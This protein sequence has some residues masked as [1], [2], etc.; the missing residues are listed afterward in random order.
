MPL[1]SPRILATIY[2]SA[3]ALVII[4]IFASPA[5]NIAAPVQSQ[6]ATTTL[7]A[8]PVAENKES[9]ATTTLEVTSQTPTP[10]AQQ[11]KNPTTP[12]V[13]KNSDTVNTDTRAALVNIFCTQEDGG[14][15]SG[16]GIIVDKRGV[17]LTNA[18]IA[19]F[20]LLEESKKVAC[21]IRAGSPAQDRYKAKLLYISTTWMQANA[22]KI[23]DRRPT[24]TGEHD[25]AFLYIT[26]N[27]DHTP[28]PTTL[29][30]RFPSV[31]MTTDRP[32]K[33][34]PV[35]LAAYPAGFLDSTII[36]KDL[37]ITSAFTLIERLLTFSDPALVDVVSV[38]G[39]VVSQAGASGGSVVRQNDGVLFGLIVTSTDAQTTASRDLKAITLAHID[40]SLAA[41]GKGGI[42]AL[43]TGNLSQKMADFANIAPGLTQ[44][45][46]DALKK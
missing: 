11:P 27:A 20:F 3:A 38:G 13:V 32:T 40:R 21:T 46:L 5:P 4:T 33:G 36:Q 22:H 26:E 39:T 2:V 18:H 12:P 29:Q 44:K 1:L 14:P 35:L 16:S 6:E 34:S 17:I 8:F 23:V 43:L 31:E 25:Y 9:P 45:L 41:E 10:P 37:Y 28:L 7:H 15:L 42:I 19:Q 30:G 24:G